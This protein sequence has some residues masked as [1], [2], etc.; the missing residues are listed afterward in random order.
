M[1][2]A[3]IKTK[4]SAIDRAAIDGSAPFEQVSKEAANKLPGVYPYPWNVV[5][6]A[7]G[8]YVNASK[9]TD[10]IIA[11]QYPTKHYYARWWRALCQAGTKLVL[12]LCQVQEELI[13]PLYFPV[14]VCNSVK[15]DEEIIVTTITCVWYSE[16]RSTIRT[17]KI[18]DGADE[19]YVTH[20]HYAGWEDGKAPSNIKTF[21]WLKQ[22]VRS[23]NVPFTVHC[24]AGIGRTGTF[25]ASYMKTQN[26]SVYE[27]VEFLR[28]KRPFSVHNETQ[29]NFLKSE[30]DELVTSNSRKILLIPMPLYEAIVPVYVYSSKSQHK[31]WELNE[32]RRV[33]IVKLYEAA[34]NML[35]WLLSEILEPCVRARLDKLRRCDWDTMYEHI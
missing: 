14:R 7:K 1:S 9:I 19:Y 4:F 20:I 8:E 18:N 28:K 31:S 24:R 16:H 25:I 6:T 15:V 12:M 21:S 5:K 10:R 27:I 35:E 26:H 11:A 2:F 30:R 13:L 29:F 17:I 23:F 32:D 3:D 34:P 22:L 33:V